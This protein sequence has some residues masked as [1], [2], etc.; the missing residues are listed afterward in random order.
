MTLMVGAK[1]APRTNVVSILVNY[2]VACPLCADITVKYM[3]HRNSQSIK[4]S[5]SPI[6]TSELIMY[7]VSYNREERYTYLNECNKMKAFKVEVFMSVVD[8]TNSQS[9]IAKRVECLLFYCITKVGLLV[10]TLHLN[11]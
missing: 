10:Q 3:N 2:T 6:E 1:M 11:N 8:V 9:N 5:N 7:I 4:P